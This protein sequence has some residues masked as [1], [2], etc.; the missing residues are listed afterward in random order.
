MWY[1]HTSQVQKQFVWGCTSQIFRTQEFNTDCEKNK[2]Q[3][4]TCSDQPSTLCVWHA[5]EARQSAIV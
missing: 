4:H 3:I 2:I 1:I 5:G